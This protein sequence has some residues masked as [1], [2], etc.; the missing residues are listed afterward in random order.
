M[1]NSP[2]Q[3]AKRL[4]AGESLSFFDSMLVFRDGRFTE[5]S[6]AYSTYAESHEFRDVRASWRDVRKWLKNGAYR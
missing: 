3:L 2:L 4:R 6:M 1:R 5:T